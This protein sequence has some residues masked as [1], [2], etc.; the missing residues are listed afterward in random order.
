MG[1]IE[2]AKSALAALD[3]YCPKDTELG[4]EFRDKAAKLQEKLSA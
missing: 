3:E 4:R 1:D 2:N